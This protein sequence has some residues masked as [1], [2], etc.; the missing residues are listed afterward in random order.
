[1]IGTPCLFLFLL[2]TPS[3]VESVPV[4][5]LANRQGPWSFL[6]L[7]PSLILLKFVEQ[8]PRLLQ[9]LHVRVFRKPAVN[10][11]QYLPALRIEL[12]PE[13][14]YGPIRVA[15]FSERRGACSQTY[16][17]RWTWLSLDEYRP[18]PPPLCP[19][20]GHASLC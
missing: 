3:V 18:S 11:G 8:R 1:M 13:A 7:F 19:G 9:I 14:R 17:R 6:A 20:N 10:L 16:L 2:S 12:K 15:L 5:G 4:S